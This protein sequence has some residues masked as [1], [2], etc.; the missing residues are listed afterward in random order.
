[1]SESKTGGESGRDGTADEV[2]LGRLGG[3]ERDRLIEHWLAVRLDNQM[4]HDLADAEPAHAHECAG[5]DEVRRLTQAEWRLAALGYDPLAEHDR[6]LMAAT[7]E[8]RR[9]AGGEA[10]VLYREF[11]AG[12]SDAAA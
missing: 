8:R 4:L 2:L 11:P 5:P 1:M 3:E 12:G 7:K 6:G 10:G 9:A